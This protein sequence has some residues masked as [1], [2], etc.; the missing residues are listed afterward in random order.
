MGNLQDRKEQ[1]ARAYNN[2][3]IS[4]LD[5]GRYE[6][7]KKYFLLAINTCLDYKYYTNL[8]ICLSELGEDME[9]L[10]N[11]DIAIKGLKEE[12]EFETKYLDTGSIT[13]IQ[14]ELDNNKTGSDLV[15]EALDELKA[16]YN[17]S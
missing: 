10:E 12:V 11:F 1:L 3:G 15:D 9:A 4:L 6:E 2:K 7:A 14:K 8:G 13:K 5:L 17:L 16:M